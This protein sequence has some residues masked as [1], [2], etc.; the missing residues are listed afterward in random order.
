MC[1]TLIKIASAIILVIAVILNFFGK[2]FGIGDIIP[3][4]PKTTEEASISQSV[5]YQE[6]TTYEYT[7]EE[8]TTEESTTEET[9]T[10]KK[11]YPVMGSTTSVTAPSVTGSTN[12]VT[13][14][15]QT[16]QEFGPKVTAVSQLA[17]ASFGGTNT[18]TYTGIDTTEDGGFV[19][20]GVSNSTDGSLLNV[21]SDSWSDYYGFVAKYDKDMN[22]V[23]IKSVG[24]AYGGVRVEDVAVLSDGS[25][26][27]VGY[28]TADDY[29]SD[30][31]SKGTLEAFAVKYSSS[32]KLEWKKIFGGQGNDLFY[33]V[34]PLGNGFVAGGKTNSTDG[35]FS[36]NSESAV[37]N[38]V[39]MNFDT[40]G[41]ILWSRYL[42]G[43]YASSVDGM[44]TDEDGNIFVASIT[45]AS[46][47]G[48]AAI[49]GM[50]KGYV[51][52]AVIK[53]N[54]DG[55]VQ[56][57]FAVAS[58]GRDNFNA[59]EA[60]GKGGCVIAGYYELV[61][62]YVPDGTFADLHNCGGIDSVVI[63][64][65]SDGTK[66]W[67]RSVAGFADDFIN[68]IVM[69]DNGGFA[70]AGY[71]SSSNRDFA[72]AGNK[73]ESDGF[74]AFITPAGNLAE[75][76]MNGGS[77]K[78]MAACAGYTSDGKLIILGKTTSSNGD[79]DGMNTHLSDTFVNLFGDAFTCYITKY[80][81]T[82]S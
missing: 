68:D 18:D 26:V 55:I 54:S 10:E 49:D 47:G 5:T 75:V 76:K 9:T 48:F 14:K 51:D 82:I 33:C 37:S 17:L 21:P 81:V 71:T 38:A 52:S 78:D 20:C 19:V 22:L 15:P 62:T 42:A 80:K 24:S 44:S 32:G 4:Q 72:S 59:I 63:R 79:F 1:N 28:S 39:I 25:V 12:A 30:S 60:D 74:A 35:S 8:S 13:T 73:G 7:T 56:W 41:N 34:E 70:V 50:G 77:R 27:A 2:L 16:T 45:A 66:Q 53:Y 6:S 64:L 3:T 40:D 61:T 11:T 29:A 46:T 31:E 57:G 36:G 67:E 23:W 69:L 43:D 65:N 58:S